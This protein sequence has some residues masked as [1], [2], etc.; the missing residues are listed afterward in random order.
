MGP[1][2]GRKEG[3]SHSSPPESCRALGTGLLLLFVCFLAP[4]VHLH[5][6]LALFPKGFSKCLEWMLHWSSHIWEQSGGGGISH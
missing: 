5:I 6:P 3:G 2:G 4:F 1:W